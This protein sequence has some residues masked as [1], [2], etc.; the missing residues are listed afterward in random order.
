MTVILLI[1]VAAQH[2]ERHAQAILVICLARHASSL[3]ASRRPT[4]AAAI[5]VMSAPTV[6]KVLVIDAG[7]GG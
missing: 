2:C 6:Q 3:I 7:L 5:S 4:L 1:R